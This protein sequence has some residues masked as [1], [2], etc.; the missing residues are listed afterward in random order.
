[1]ATKG[2][3]FET[4]TPENLQAQLAD[5]SR[6]LADLTA[7]MVYDDPGLLKPLLELSWSDNDPWSNRASRII[8]ICVGRF[9]DLIIPYIPRMIK[10]LARQ[11]S[12]GVTRNFLKILS[13]IPLELSERDMATLL[14]LSF[15]YLSENSAVA[16]KVYAMQIL[17]NL[18]H[19]LPEIK[20]ELYH[21][22]DNQILE[23]TPGF[24]S[25]G[26]KILKKLYTGFDFAQ[27]D[28]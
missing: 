7:N 4:V 27:P 28:I 26:K 6:A 12:E 14:D 18:S 9:P 25:R 2:K 17:Y 22:I 23:A 16:I 11:R 10:R 8:S 15:K 21:V 24:K 3:T 5:S 13:E 20:Q 19:D 1:M